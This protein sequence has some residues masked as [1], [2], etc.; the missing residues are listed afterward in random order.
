[1]IAET[2]E[3]D[4]SFAPA[5]RRLADIVRVAAVAASSDE[6]AGKWCELVHAARS[7]FGNESEKTR[8]VCILPTRVQEPGELVR[9]NWDPLGC[10]ASEI[11]FS[12]LLRLELEPF[13][14][15]V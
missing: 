12:N 4:Q 5:A 15:G 13:I 7:F 10:P 9:V 1:M 3:N 8:E 11:E 14:K 6:F 2:E